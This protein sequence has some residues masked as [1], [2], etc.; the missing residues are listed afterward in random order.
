MSWP[1]CKAATVTRGIEALRTPWISAA[2][3]LVRP[4]AMAERMKSSFIT[5]SIAV[6]TYRAKTD[7]TPR[8][9][10]QIGMIADRIA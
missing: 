3:R 9:N 4:R 5:S 1:N 10:A 6:R 8:L 7:V 2:P